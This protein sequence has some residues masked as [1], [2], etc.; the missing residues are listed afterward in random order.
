MN[1]AACLKKTQRIS[2]SSCLQDKIQNFNSKFSILQEEISKII[3]NLKKP[4]Y[5]NVLDNS[6]ILKEILNLKT[7]IINLRTIN[8]KSSKKSRILLEIQT[9]SEIIQ[10]LK[11]EISL[12]NSKLKKCQEILIKELFILFNCRIQTF[13]DSNSKLFINN[14]YFN[15][16]D[17][18]NSLCIRIRCAIGYLQS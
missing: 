1:C 6:Q 5:P 15:P 16:Y 7:Q 11:S 17:N 2:C 12:L 4:K 13:S 8:Q 18:G 10:N 9:K 14:L 3:E